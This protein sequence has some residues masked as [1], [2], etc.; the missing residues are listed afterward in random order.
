MPEADKIL[1]LKASG[2]HGK[3]SSQG[4]RANAHETH[5]PQEDE[6][7]EITPD[8][9]AGI[10]V[11]THISSPAAASRPANASDYLSQDEELDDDLLQLVV[12]QHSKG[13]GIDI[14]TLMSQPSMFKKG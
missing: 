6:E 5:D 10:R 1:I 2:N 13:K 3:D 7:D 14:N 11:T 8:E 4:R 12:T 9:R